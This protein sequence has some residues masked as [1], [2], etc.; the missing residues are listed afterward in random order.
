MRNPHRIFA[1]AA[2]LAATWPFAGTLAAQQISMEDGWRFHPDTE[3]AGTG[4]GFTR[5][6]FDDS[7]WIAIKTGASWEEQGFEQLDGFAWYRRRFSLDSAP[8]T[9]AML[10]LGTIDDAD[11]VFINGTRIGGTGVFPPNTKVAWGRTRVYKIP[12]ELLHSGE[13][14]IAI[15]VFDEGGDGGMRSGFHRLTLGPETAELL[16]LRTRRAGGFANANFAMAMELASD[17]EF[18]ARI[19]CN[20]AA[21]GLWFEE[22]MLG[23]LAFREGDV[24]IAAPDMLSGEVRRLWPFSRASYANPAI[25]NIQIDLESFCPVARA[26]VPYLPAA[27]L[28]LAAFKITNKSDRERNIEIVWRF[29]LEGATLNVAAED[30][31][32]IA[33]SGFDGERVSVRTEA[34]SGRFEGNLIKFWT[35]KIK[36]APGET[37]EIHYCFAQSPRTARGSTDPGNWPNSNELALS[38]LKNF[39]VIYRE[40][41]LIDQW[42]PV[43]GDPK[44]DAAF[45]QY[46]ANAVQLTKVSTGGAVSVM[47]Y[48]EMT[49]RDAYW[50]TFLH[51]LLFPDLEQ[52]MIE[53]AL[54]EQRADGKIPTSVLPNSDRED[55]VDTNAYAMLRAFRYAKWNQDHKFL[56]KIA[57]NLKG[58][59]IWLNSRDGDGDGVPDMHS[60][61]GDWKD[62]P[63]IS[64]RKYSPHAAFVYI[65]ALTQ[66]IEVMK[67]GRDDVSAVMEF[68]KRLQRATRT[69]DGN[70]EA[71]GLWNG[72][73]YCERWRGASESAPAETAAIRNQKIVNE[74]QIVGIFFDVVPRERINLIFDS[75]EANRGA[76]GIR[77]SYPYRPA[78][79]GHRP[80]EFTN[81]AVWPWLNYADA[82]ARLRAGRTSD[83]I[84][85]LKLVAR[86]DLLQSGG[87]MPNECLDGETGEPLRNAPQ[88]WNSDFVGAV[89]HGMFG[90]DRD[91]NGLLHIEPRALLAR[92][93]RV[94]IP[95]PEGDLELRDGEGDNPPELSWALETELPVLVKLPDR[96]QWR[97]I[98]QPGKNRHSFPV[99]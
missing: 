43:T 19:W 98:L 4:L 9:D 46:C 77:E 52:K 54:G 20:P 53:E 96:P 3:N 13:N 68:E 16:K 91:W 35:S 47:A 29:A 94:R 80:G 12:R 23:R 70:F 82:W 56:S 81:G 76:A 85:L 61:W 25:S 78:A 41:S 26:G 75:L 18:P 95:V 58:A 65:A 10:E 37:R 87:S 71:G 89:F 2:W 28:G 93:W 99:K 67:L 66:L 5:P 62:L 40:T 11:E 69:V 86:Y 17:G 42:L 73:Y 83:G 1:A 33:Y 8:S 15:R 79:A 30:R 32:G 84:E 22:S 97:S 92:G 59:A 55:D 48:S 36:L 60:R 45:R 63:G 21:S 90:I 31:D 14:T 72:K 74:D 49:Q 51:N 6:D 24:E 7:K 39:N 38:G 57:A 50:G 27:P 44:I 34:P 88:L 64:E